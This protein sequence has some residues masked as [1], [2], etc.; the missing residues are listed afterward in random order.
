MSRVGT[1]NATD[2]RSQYS[3]AVP[4]SDDRVAT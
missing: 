2:C 1:R 3:T 4:S